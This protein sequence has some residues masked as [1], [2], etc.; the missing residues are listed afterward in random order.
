VYVVARGHNSLDEA[1]TCCNIANVYNSQGKYDQA[2][3]YY[4]K[5]LEITVRLVGLDHP[6]VATSKYNVA[7]AY[8]KQGKL[9]EAR[10]L[11][12]ECEQIYSK[13]HGAQ[14]EETVDAAR[15][16]ATVGRIR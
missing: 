5:D 7:S 16:A 13:V 12:L 2:L 14:H 10:Q 9:E 4:Q 15:R 11:F 1:N 6:S 3:E 8:E